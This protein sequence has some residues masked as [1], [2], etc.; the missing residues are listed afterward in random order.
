LSR[1]R[2]LTRF[3]QS[4]LRRFHPYASKRFAGTL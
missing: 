2:Q 3:Q 1:S 4:I